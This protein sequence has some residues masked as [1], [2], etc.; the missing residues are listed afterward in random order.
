MVEYGSALEHN[1]WVGEVGGKAYNRTHPRQY[2]QFV[3]RGGPIPVPSWG[4]AWSGA[5]QFIGG[6][7]S[8]MR[9]LGAGIVYSVEPPGAATPTAYTYTVEF[10]WLLSTGI[11]YCSFVAWCATVFLKRTG[12]PERKGEQP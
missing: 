6:V 4:D 8:G 7:G 2:I 9:G 12:T 11:L 1:G 3:P 10:V 5:S